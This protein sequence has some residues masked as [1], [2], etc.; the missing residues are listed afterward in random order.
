MFYVDASVWV[1]A[2]TSEPDTQRS[3]VWL[4]SVSGQTAITPF[5]EVEVASALS[6]KVR[7]RTLPAREMAIAWRMFREGVVGSAIL[8]Q[9]TASHMAA[10]ARLAGRPELK[11][12]AGDALHIAVADEADLPLCTLDKTMRAAALTLGLEVVDP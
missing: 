5:T 10:A 3:Q 8:L 4:A 7:A 9:V 1:A 11:L 12:R 6:L 2:L